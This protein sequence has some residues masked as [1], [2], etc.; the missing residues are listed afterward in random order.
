[1]FE[2]SRRHQCAGA[3]PRNIA[4]FWVVVATTL[5]LGA[6]AGPITRPPGPQCAQFSDQ[7]STSRAALALDT[8]TAPDEPY[9]RSLQRL[10]GKTTPSSPRATEP[11]PGTPSA[12]APVVLNLLV[13]SGGAEWGAYGSGFLNGMYGPAAGPPE[14]PLKDYNIITGISTGSIMA[15]DIWSAII[16]AKR[17]DL[18]DSQRFLEDLQGIYSHTDADLFV[19]ENALFYALGSNG[20]V[21]PTGRLDKLLA[22]KYAN[23]SAQNLFRGDGAAVQ[24]DV[25]AVNLTDGKFYSY[26]LPDIA[27]RGDANALNCFS[28]VILSSAAIPLSFPPRFMDGSPYVDGGVRFLVYIDKFFN[29]VRA[30]AQGRPIT[31]N[32]RVIINGNQSPNDPGQDAQQAADCDNARAGESSE[33]SC[34][35]VSQTLLGSFIP[36]GNGK[37]IVL[38]VTQD[39]MIHQ[40]KRD[41]LYRLYTDWKLSGTKGTF[42]YTYVSNAELAHPPAGAGVQ[43]PCQ[44]K[45]SNHFDLAFQSCLFRIGQY[46]GSHNQWEPDTAMTG[47][48]SD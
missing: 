11:S 26:S 43:G 4:R 35:G 20:L 48:P 21:N 22:E 24:V 18:A 17:G 47:A 3:G 40:L 38:R 42:R 7:Y 45:S 6:C 31:V 19:T 15:P 44:A 16:Y 29:D 13:L 10:F 41:S 36:G 33:S 25:G 34:P 30:E 1:M 23:P 9:G 39:V 2:T 8:K 14:I 27:A 32:V 28:E 46:K 37:G 5:A 12:T